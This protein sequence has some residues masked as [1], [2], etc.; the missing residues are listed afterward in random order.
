MSLVLV[1]A[2][3]SV[4]LTVALFAGGALIGFTRLVL[5]GPA[6]M[7][8]PAVLPP[9]EPTAPRAPQRLRGSTP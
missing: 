6:T 9:H 5:R 7:R 4:A 3:F 8:S 1:I 2:A